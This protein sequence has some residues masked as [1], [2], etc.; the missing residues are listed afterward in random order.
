MVSSNSK[1]KKV[2]SSKAKKVTSSFLTQ[3][4]SFGCF[5]HPSFSADFSTM[6]KSQ[7]SI[8]DVET[9]ILEHENSIKMLEHDLEIAP[10]EALFVHQHTVRR[11]SVLQ[12]KVRKLIM[13]KRIMQKSPTVKTETSLT[14]IPEL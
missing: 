13:V 9:K 8:T 2:T 7:S 10:P 5:L 12:K 3:S 4:G 14:S 1:A 11:I 6:G